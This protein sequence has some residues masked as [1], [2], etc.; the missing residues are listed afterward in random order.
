MFILHKTLDVLQPR[1]ILPLLLIIHKAHQVASQVRSHTP[2][3]QVSHQPSLHLFIEL[4]EHRSTIKG[5]FDVV[6]IDRLIRD[7]LDGEVAAIA[8]TF[9][10]AK[11]GKKKIS[12]EEAVAVRANATC[13]VYYQ[14]TR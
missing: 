2:L 8:P 1:H 6:R 11:K 7:V 13:H 10:P 3:F 4:F 14:S 9:K 12:N 5:I